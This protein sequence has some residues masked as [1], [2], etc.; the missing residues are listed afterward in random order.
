MQEFSGNYIP[1][2]Y[3]LQ[4]RMV[5]PIAGSDKNRIFVLIHTRLYMAKEESRSVVSFFF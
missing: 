1:L 5:V 4:A 3:K 2:S